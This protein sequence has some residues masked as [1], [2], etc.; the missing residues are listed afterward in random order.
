MMLLQHFFFICVGSI[1]MLV[2]LLDGVTFLA[3]ELALR[4]V[5][6]VILTTV[7]VWASSVTTSKSARERKMENS[8]WIGPSWA[9]SMPHTL[10]HGLSGLLRV[11]SLARHLGKVW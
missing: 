3:T 4:T 10:S 7:V 6:W 11:G 1:K 9:A 5:Q 2:T 8:N